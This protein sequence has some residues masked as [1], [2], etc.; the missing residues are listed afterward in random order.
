M[1]GRR[2]FVLGVAVAIAVPAGAA[3]ATTANH[4]RPS[5]PSAP[6]MPDVAAR[7]A[8]LRANL[9][10]ADEDERA[11]RNAGDRSDQWWRT[12]VVAPRTEVRR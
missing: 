10:R 11:R 12:T 7:V 6:W 2:S 1:R 9:V 4:A 3:F 8:S 5:A